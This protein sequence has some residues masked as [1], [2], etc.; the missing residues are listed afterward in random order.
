[1]SLPTV[2]GRS[3]LRKVLA[4]AQSKG[5]WIAILGIAITLGLLTYGAF[6]FRRDSPPP[7]SVE[8]DDLFS[9]RSGLFKRGRRD[10]PAVCLTFDDGPHPGSLPQILDTLKAFRVKATFFLVG[11]RI[12][13]RPDEVREILLEGHEVG[14]HT[15]NHIRLDTLNPD[16]IR[17][18]LG[19][20]ADAFEQASRGRK[21]ALFRAPGMRVDPVV[22]KIAREFGY[23]T[24]SANYGAKD[25]QLVKD[26]PTVADANEIVG[27]V[28]DQLT[29][30]GIILLHDSPETAEALPEILSGIQKRGFRIES[31]SRM[32]ADLPEPVWVHSNAGPTR[33]ATNQ[34]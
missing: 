14:N 8:T 20:C 5:W 1:M 31:V 13:Q 25:F 12:R 33:A 26:G 32:L 24:V 6:A 19:L 18:E 17:V 28:L 4:T 11:R 7:K 10:Q 21:M 23:V 9:A 3:W 22:L 27:Y 30:G 16:Q 2:A 34:P 29:P 15:E